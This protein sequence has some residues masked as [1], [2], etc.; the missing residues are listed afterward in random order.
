MFRQA[1]LRLVLLFGDWV[2]LTVAMLLASWLRV[3]LAYG[4]P[5]D[6]AAAWLSLTIY[7]LILIVWALGFMMM[8]VY[9][10][11]RNL[12]LEDEVIRL[13][14]AHAGTTLAFAGALYFLARETSRLQILYFAAISWVLLVAFRCLVRLTMGSRSAVGVGVRRV[15]IIGAGRVGREVAQMVLSHHWTGLQFVGFVDDNWH[16]NT[17]A[18]RVDGTHMKY[19]H[20]GSLAR[21][22]DV[23]QEQQIHEAIIALPRSAHK[24]LAVLVAGLQQLRVNIRVVPDLVDLVFSRSGIE[25]FGGIPLVTLRDPVLDPMQRLTK[26]VFDLVVSLVAVVLTLPI[27]GLAAAAIWFDTGRPILFR[28]RRV[29]E[30]GHPFD[31]LKFRTMIVGADSLPAPSPD[32]GAPVVHK[33][34]DDPRVT[35]VGRWLRRFSIDE[36]PQLFN[37]LHGDMSL[38]GPRPELPWLV[39]RYEPWQRKRFEVP[40]GITGWWQVNG[41]SNRLMHL[42]T[43]DDLYYIRNYSLLLDVKILWRTVRAVLTRHGAY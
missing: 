25:D 15:L 24:K 30:K 26:R 17:T 42:H 16:A 11:E 13:T 7:A 36:L 14:A 34:R 1:G 41:R 27:M 21:A 2:T 38:V 3:A 39:D 43:E 5:L 29:G 9:V 31:I 10:L 4:R 40:Q 12:K 37:V 28:Q 22:V 6:E 32:D 19:P 8:H 23:A 35:R 33:Q 20:F 18:L